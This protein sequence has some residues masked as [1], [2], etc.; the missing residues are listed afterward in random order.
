MTDTNGH[1]SLVVEPEVD[2]IRFSMTG[3]RP[4]TKAVKTKMSQEINLSLSPRLNVLSEVIV[5]P[6]G[7]DPAVHLFRKIIKHKEQNNPAHFTSYRCEAYDKLEFDASN[8]PGKITHSRLL[9]PFSFVFDYK[10]S[11]D[12]REHQIPVFLAES[13][14]NYYYS[15]DPWIEKTI[16]RA[17]KI[18]G[19]KNESVIK[20]LDDMKQR[21][22]IYDN[23]II[24]LKIPFISPLADNGLN[25]YK[26]TIEETKFINER[27]YYRL[28][29]RPLHGGSNTFRGECWIM[30]KT[31]ALTSITMEMN[32]GA[33]INWVKGIAI[34]QDFIQLTDS[35]MVVSKS[36]LTISF[37]T[38]SKKSL[39]FIGRK[40]SY[41]RN[42]E[43]NVPAGDSSLNNAPVIAANFSSLQQDNQ[44]WEQNRFVPLTA[45]EKWVYTMVDSVQKVPAFTTY[46]HIITALSTG[47]YPV[48]KIDLG[49]I[50]STFTSNVIEGARFDLGLRTNAKFNN[51][52][53]LKGYAGLGTKHNTVKYALSSLF[54]LNRKNWETLKLSYEDDFS[55]LS[56][57]NNELDEHSVF[58]AMMSRVPK[59]DIRLVNN[60]QAKIQYLHYYQKGFSLQLA[61]DRRVLSPAFNTY[62]TYGKFTPSIIPVRGAYLDKS[63]NVSEATV[64]LRYAHRENILNGPFSRVNLGSRYPVIEFRYTRGFRIQEGALK[65]DFNYNKYQ[66]SVSQHLLIP[67]FGKVI[68]SIEGGITDGVLPILLLDVAKGNNTYYYDRYAFNNMNRYEFVSDHYA[69]LLLEH[70][71]GGFPFNRLP[72]IRKLKWR[73]VASFRALTGTMTDA[74]KAANRYY[75]S[76]LAYH[77]TVPD[78]QPYMESGIGIENIFHLLR[79]DAVWRLSYKNRPDIVKFGLK[80]SIQFSF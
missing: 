13:I 33:N 65:S 61:A 21:I 56:D 79:I 80:A 48:G 2:S 19:I 44:F 63:Y 50:Y 34:A 37:S 62:Y 23:Y 55:S 49:N 68:Y 76:S 28:S 5:Y 77:F 4:V 18:T 40:T 64:G 12:Q 26:Y 27:R 24:F 42:I 17:K 54:V 11:S 78:R 39:G 69:S 6:K 75:D 66:V 3:Y 10:D 73:T 31:Y 60:R 14:G 38:L 74:N 52:V 58:G 22:N 35:T 47:Y 43:L 16:Y 51:R 1:Y 9:Q 67:G 71:W 59:E 72:L 57:H 20:Y 45:S 30:D 25:Y 36:G 8:I 15:K 70:H 41:Y 32:E 29:F 46:S 53:Q 7:Y